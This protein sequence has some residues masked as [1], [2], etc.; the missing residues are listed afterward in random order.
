MNLQNIKAQAQTLSKVS[1]FT[2][3]NKVFPILEYYTCTTAEKE[4][5]R[6][7]VYYNGMSVGVIGHIE[8]YLQSSESYIKGQVIRL[9]INEENHMVEDIK[10]EI[11][12][13]V[14]IK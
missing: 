11:Y 14:F 6:N 7:K 8:D 10:N 4:A 9:N 13:G 12:K 1:A 5:L 2:P 3:N